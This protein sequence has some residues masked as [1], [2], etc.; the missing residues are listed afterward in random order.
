MFFEKILTNF[1][2]FQ[3]LFDH[4][5]GMSALLLFM[6]PVARRFRHIRQIIKFRILSILLFDNFFSHEWIN[7]F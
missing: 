1:A 4:I 6:L 3:R 5:Y 7:S 2:F